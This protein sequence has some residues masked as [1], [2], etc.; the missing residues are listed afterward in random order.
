[1][2]ESELHKYRLTGMEEPS[3]ELMAALMERAAEEAKRKNEVAHKAFWAE[4]DK[5]VK[6]GGLPQK[7]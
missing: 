6:E 1:M 5:I 2:S 7:R 3:D 4:L